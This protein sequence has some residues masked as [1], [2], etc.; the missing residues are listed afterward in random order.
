MKRIGGIVLALIMVL[1]LIPVV[2][3]GAQEKKAQVGKKA[4]TGTFSYT[5]PTRS[6]NGYSDVVSWS[7][8]VSYFSGA[9]RFGADP[10][11]SLTVRGN[12]VSGTVRGLL[13][14]ED[15]EVKLTYH[16]TYYWDETEAVYGWYHSC[17]NREEGHTCSFPG[18]YSYGQT[19]TT[20]VRKSGQDSGGIT[21]KGQTPKDPNVYD[22]H[23]LME[24]VHKYNRLWLVNDV[25][26]NGKEGHIVV[27]G[28]ARKRWLHEPV[29]KVSLYGNNRTVFYTG[30]DSYCFQVGNDATLVAE[31]LKV[32]SCIGS[33]LEQ[34]SVGG[35]Y[36]AMTAKGGG[37]AFM[38]GR[39][40]GEADRPRD[41][42]L[43]S[44]GNLILRSVEA[45]AF[46]KAVY[47]ARG[48]VSVT[49]CRLYGMG[50]QDV[51]AARLQTD[52]SGICVGDPTVLH[53]D[54]CRIRVEDSTVT[55]RFNGIFLQG[56]TTCQIRGC[57]LRGDCG[58][59]IDQRGTGEVT[60][61]DCRL[62]GAKGID[63]FHD[64]D[65][66]AIMGA[67]T[68]RRTFSKEGYIRQ[69][70][71][72][73]REKRGS[74]R[75]GHSKIC[76]YTGVFSGN[77]DLSCAGIQSNA[78]VVM[79]EGVEIEARR[80]GAW[81]Q[82]EAKSVAAGISTATAL[83]IPRDALVYG[84]DY[85]IKVRRQLSD[86]QWGLESSFA[87]AYQSLPKDQ[88]QKDLRHLVKEY[89]LTEEAASSGKVFDDGGACRI[90]VKGKVSSKGIGIFNGYGKVYLQSGADIAGADAG[91]KNGAA[92]LA[93]EKE[94]IDYEHLPYPS[95]FIEEKEQGIRIASSAQG[96]ALVNK[97]CAKANLGGRYKRGEEPGVL[98]TGME[99]NT[100]C[101]VGIYNEGSLVL[102]SGR[103]R[104]AGRIFDN[105]KGATALLEAVAEDASAGRKTD[106][107]VRLCD[108]QIG[109]MNRGSLTLGRGV[110][111]S[112][113]A[114]A[115]V[116]QKGT[117]IM[118]PG[119]C[120]DGE[121][122]D[123]N[124]IFLDRT[125]ENGET[126]GHV[127]DVYGDLYGVA[128]MA[129]S[130]GC[131]RIALGEGDRKPGRE[132]IRLFSENGRICYSRDKDLQGSRK[133]EEKKRIIARTD[134]LAGENANGEDDR[135]GLFT[136]D[137]DRVHV[138]D[139]K[140]MPHPSALRSGLGTYVP[141]EKVGE[142]YQP[143]AGAK[144]NGN[145]GTVVLSALLSA[146]Y[147]GNIQTAVDGVITQD[148]KPTSYYWS[149]V[150]TFTTDS[151]HREAD[152]SR[153]FYEK[154]GKR[155]E[156]TCAFVQKGWC[157]EKEGSPGSLWHEDRRL[158]IYKEDHTFYGQWDMD[159][160][161]YFH[162]NGQTNGAKNYIGKG[163]HLGDVLPGNDGP[164]HDS[165]PYFEKQVA[166]RY[167]DKNAGGEIDGTKRYSWQGWSLS[168]DAVYTDEGVLQK[169]SGL[170]PDTME[171]FLQA[172][173]QDRWNL[174]QNR[175]VV[176]VYAVWDE[177]PEIQAYDSSLYDR[178]LCDRSE[179]NRQAIMKK[180]LSPDTVSAFDRE[181][182]PVL[183]E[184]IHVYTD[185]KHKTFALEDL[186]ELG[187]VGEAS[188]FY[189]VE[190]KWQ[191]PKE[192]WKINQT[193]YV[194]KLFVLTSD[195]QDSKEVDEKELEEG[196][197]ESGG[198][199]ATED[200]API[201]VRKIDTATLGLLPYSVWKEKAYQREL[202]DALAA[203]ERLIS[204]NAVAS[205]EQRKAFLAEGS[206]H[207]EK[208]TGYMQ[209]RWLFT[210]KQ[211]RQAQS[212]TRE[213]GYEALT[214]KGLVA[215]QQAFSSCKTYDRTGLL[216]EYG[217]RIFCDEGNRSLRINWDACKEADEI[218]LVLDGED[219]SYRSRTI[220]RKGNEEE[221]TSCV[222]GGL[223][224]DT[225]YR[226]T[227]ETSSHGK[228]AHPSFARARTR[229]IDRPS[230]TA[231]EKG[232]G[233][234]DLFFD[235]DGDAD[236]YRVQRRLC[237]KENRALPWEDLV[238]IDQDSRDAGGAYYTDHT[239]SMYRDVVTEGVYEYR[240]RGEGQE[241]CDGAEA[242][243]VYGDWSECVEAAFVPEVEGVRLQAGYRGILVQW[244]KVRDCDGYKVLYRKRDGTQKEVSVP[245]EKEEVFLG[246]L[247][248]DAVYTIR[249]YA[250]RMGHVSLCRKEYSGRTL[251]LEPPKILTESKGYR[252]DGIHLLFT[253]DPAGECAQ[254][255][256]RKEGEA[257][258]V[259]GEVPCD[260]KARME[261]VD[262]PKETGCYTYRIRVCV[263][264]PDQ[265]TVTSKDSEERE[266]GYVRPL[267]VKGGGIP[268]GKEQWIEWEKDKN[269]TGYVVFYYYCGDD[270]R[271]TAYVDRTAHQ[272]LLRGQNGAIRSYEVHTVYSRHGKAYVSL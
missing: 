169:G 7:G 19:G 195:S 175:A 108:G 56:D 261:F 18:C 269:A 225:D 81:Y 149:E 2:S 5:L 78:D 21:Q 116:W 95:L 173:K 188:I 124:P 163:Y 247:S 254:I 211:I 161:L 205:E 191:H 268:H 271:H 193:V 66:D 106:G 60:V 42:M 240:I 136:L 69:L 252:E 113:N 43:Y 157:D 63:C 171:F 79:E 4:F 229:G 119:A 48:D 227:M 145:V 49:D 12:T 152:R 167:Y 107:A 118:K 182:G 57:I 144:Q 105:A 137:F 61:E 244:E 231:K 265:K 70:S 135:R 236:R 183:Q 102:S 147:R 58:D 189:E 36:T 177:Y 74:L 9:G 233:R 218:R 263:K 103:I 77:E 164:T 185:L 190:D 117:F 121:G 134:I 64:A 132:V 217:L 165:E 159:I 76:V 133:T 28:A 65:C 166:G 45:Y 272:I 151:D 176:T 198:S 153:V 55:G 62:Y 13:D 243:P 97:R 249:I 170:P 242:P 146:S 181:D 142:N 114:K 82:K 180:L 23:D 101:G 232:D 172:V 150:Q 88:V 110:N 120:V 15:W 184:K 59:C 111:V 100:G 162:G 266:Y 10:K 168:P 83:D 3:V 203:N 158:A 228:K 154:D 264:E 131:G 179:E 255:L 87:D 22:A 212:F 1:H 34:K 259:V 194:S 52:G 141:E 129:E 199:E 16:R 26:V 262:H 238:V 174:E 11:V 260:G 234:I 44:K 245:A 123:G 206:D 41:L 239:R 96:K 33:I 241:L 72:V 192:G 138:G 204:N 196:R 47:I 222:M 127:I 85:G 90:L 75:I 219:G 187:D 251:F 40:Y 30:E 8:S 160:D 73:P 230:L 92:G 209:Q 267:H 53:S 71:Y 31:D 207:F 68:G 213:K 257:E 37:G 221:R 46:S 226:I 216:E 24:K 38:A 94:M 17:S 35:E 86:L 91:I 250:K 220:T 80:S 143:K 93:D 122:E 84:D 253:L 235:L 67:L 125:T 115:G 128:P 224:A 27:D 256:R 140:K 270:T 208:S 210:G 148:P 29:H 130:G 112:G 214:G 186:R 50:R 246:D 155:K 25:E 126:I 98:Y 54:H 202:K 156:L 51:F 197:N 99:E 89:D 200:A 109:I 237:G 248:E 215:W 20:T 223:K 258:R 6:G 139:Q 39:Y 32:I 201:Y 104:A 178:Q 14:Y